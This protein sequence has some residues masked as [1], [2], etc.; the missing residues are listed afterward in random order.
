MKHPESSAPLPTEERSTEEPF[1]AELR[2][3][4]ELLE[5]IVAD[6]GLLASL[7]REDYLRFL[8]A[9]EHAYHPDPVARR[10]LV[11]ATVRLRKAE[12]TR[13][14]EAKLHQTGIRELRRKPVFT[15]PN[16]FPPSEPQLADA[17]AET[18][19][20]GALGPQHCYVCKEDFT[21]VHH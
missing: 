7:G 11:K 2:S 21:Q 12:K 5:R 9:V 16:Y 8:A 20:R 10:K 4:I 13:L 1:A 19:L 15:T 14:D 6:R 18:E 3:A 17:E